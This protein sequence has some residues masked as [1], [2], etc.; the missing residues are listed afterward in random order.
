MAA[1][2]VAENGDSVDGATAFKVLP[3]LLSSGRIINLKSIIRL[4]WNL[5]KLITTHGMK[6]SGCN[7]Y[8]NI[9][10]YVEFAPWSLN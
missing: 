3:Q 6:I 1:V 9:E 2:F 4:Q 7:V 5:A 10:R 8:T